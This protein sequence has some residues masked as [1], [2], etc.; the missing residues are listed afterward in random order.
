MS[1]S[2]RTSTA[3]SG[4]FVPVTKADANLPNGVCRALRVGTAGTANLMD[5]EGN[6]RTNVPLFAGD[7]SLSVLQVRTGGTADDIW[8]LY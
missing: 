8:A 4:F 5:T 1:R 3:T 7:N 6:I 2:N